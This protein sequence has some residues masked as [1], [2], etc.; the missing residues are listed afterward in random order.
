M[1]TLAVTVDLPSLMLAEVKAKVL[2]SLSTL[3]KLM[4]VRTVLNCSEIGL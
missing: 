3:M 1:A 4:L 2:I